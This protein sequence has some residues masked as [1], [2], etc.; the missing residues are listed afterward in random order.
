MPSLS[1]RLHTY[2]YEHGALTAFESGDCLSSSCVLFIGGL[3]EVT[4]SVLSCVI[5]TI[6]RDIWR[7]HI[8]H[9]S[10]RYSRAEIGVCVNST[11]EAAI[12]DLGLAVCNVIS[13]I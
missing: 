11:C 12:W 10:L 4:F 1:G 7:H 2:S 13:K 8:F 6:L 3:T 9:C 5:L